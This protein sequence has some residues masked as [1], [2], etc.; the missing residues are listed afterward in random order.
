MLKH[1]VRCALPKSIFRK[2]IAAGLLFFPR[3]LPGQLSF[4]ELEKAH[5][6][7]FHAKCCSVCP[8]TCK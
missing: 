5:Q 3:T 1:S 2:A 6:L 4:L 8:V 7:L